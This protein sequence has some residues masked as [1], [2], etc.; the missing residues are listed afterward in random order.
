MLIILT[1]IDETTLLSRETIV[2]TRTTRQIKITRWFP[3]ANEEHDENALTRNSQ[4]RLKYQFCTDPITSSATIFN[5]RIF[6]VFSRNSNQFNQKWTDKK[7]WL[8]GKWSEQ[9]SVVVVLNDTHARPTVQRGRFQKQ[10]RALKRKSLRKV[11]IPC[12]SLSTGYKITITV[13]T[14]H[15]YCYN[16]LIRFIFSAPL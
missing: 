8:N 13:V 16:L 4:A 14:S 2:N 5:K 1:A 3:S 11:R 12:S 15:Y 6:P 9:L 7:M 10:D